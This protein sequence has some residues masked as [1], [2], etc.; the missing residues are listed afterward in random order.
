GPAAGHTGAAP[1]STRR[2]LRHLP[3][4]DRPTPPARAGSHPTSSTPPH[5]Y[6][7]ASKSRR[8]GLNFTDMESGRLYTRS[9]S[10]SGAGHP[11]RCG[12][13]CVDV[14]PPRNGPLRAGVLFIG[15]EA[16]M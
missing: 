2:W 12:P 15:A 7:W 3:P 11:A 8:L 14:G 5:V 16:G 9:I 10:D 6:P 1:S 4:T 13:R